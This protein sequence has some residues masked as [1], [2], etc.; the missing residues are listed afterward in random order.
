[1]GLTKLSDYFRPKKLTEAIRLLKENDGYFPI[2]GGSWLIPYGGSEVRGIVDLSEAGI[3]EIRLEESSMYIGA[4]TT[5]S[6]LIIAPETSAHP[7]GFI[8]E[9]INSEGSTRLINS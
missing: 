4:S 9:S 5:L 8:R 3:R 2:G 7:Y 1:M 6:D